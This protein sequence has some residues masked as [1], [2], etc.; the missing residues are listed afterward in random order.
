V[1]DA[2]TGDSFDI[3]SDNGGG[4]DDD[5]NNINTGPNI[6]SFLE[7]FIV[8]LTGLRKMIKS[9]L[10]LTNKVLRHEHLWGSGC[11]SPRFLDLGTIWK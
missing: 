9:S 5:N 10:C 6:S 4:G 3:G 11:I 7:R 1:L 8:L 2:G